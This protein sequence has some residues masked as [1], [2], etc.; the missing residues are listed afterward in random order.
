V[1]VERLRVCSPHPVDALLEVAAERNPAIL[2]FGPDPTQLRPRQY[3]K[4][5]RAVRERAACLVWTAEV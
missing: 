2:V 5:E 3:R 4:A 1:R